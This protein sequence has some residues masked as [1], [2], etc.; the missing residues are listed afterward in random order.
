MIDE[1]EEEGVKLLVRRKGIFGVVC[2]SETQLSDV[3][4]DV[5]QLRSCCAAAFG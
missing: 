3:N 4:I 2:G 5:L 1:I